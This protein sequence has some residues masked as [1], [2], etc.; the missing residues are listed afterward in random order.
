M[1]QICQ[2]QIKDFRGI[3]QLEINDIARINLFVGLNSVGKSSILEAV[4][5]ACSGN[6]PME[7]MQMNQ[8]R[9]L[10]ASHSTLGAESYFYNYDLGRTPK[11][12]IEI[13]QTGPI[14]T[15]S[16]G[17]HSIAMGWKADQSPAPIQTTV[18]ESGQVVAA[19]SNLVNSQLGSL[20]VTYKHPPNQEHESEIAFVPNGSHTKRFEACSY[21]IQSKFFSLGQG[22]NIEIAQWISKQERQ[23]G[24][25]A[26]VNFMKAVDVRIEDVFVSAETQPA[27]ASFVLA[28]Q[29]KSYPIAL[30]GD[31]VRRAAE[32]AHGLID[33]S[34]KV[35]CIDEVDAG[36]H[37]D[38]MIGVWRGIYQQVKSK[39]SQVFA[40]THDREMVVRLLN[41]VRETEDGEINDICLHQI[42]RR[43]DGSIGVTSIR[44]SEIED[45]IQADL[46]LMR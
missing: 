7:F 29:E 17:S 1:E 32:F 20:V 38:A 2:I 14:K 3:E 39:E 24:K 18:N 12:T 6:Q 30:M 15:A 44:G 10:Y 22:I 8:A 33:S 45:N 16:S 13:C 9:R 25:S 27:S 34:T 21:C 19:V 40:T 23:G 5:L 37:K 41:A 31:G 26:F 4:H 35:V 28:G 36:I 11:C 43:S 42:F 46:E